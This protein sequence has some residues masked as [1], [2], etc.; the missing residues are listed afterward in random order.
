VQVYAESTHDSHWYDDENLYRYPIDDLLKHIE[1]DVDTMRPHKTAPNS[2]AAFLSLQNNISYSC[3][4]HDRNV[5]ASKRK[6]SVK[7]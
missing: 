1:A 2:G 6:P 5:F 7:I 3:F 4:G